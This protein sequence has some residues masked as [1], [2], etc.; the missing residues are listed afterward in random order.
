MLRNRDVRLIT[1]GRAL[2]FLGDQ[3]A[4]VAVLLH[5]HASGWG[6][7]GVAAVLVASA[8]PL[9][10]GA[11]LA[12]RL[13]DRVASRLL[14]VGTVVWEGCCVLALALLIA[15]VPDGPAT[16]G[17]TLVLLFAL[18]AG[19]AVSGPAWTALVPAVTERDEVGRAVG[20]VQAAMT[21]M[22]VAGPA[23]GGVLV[24]W[25][26]TVTA[27]AVDAGSFA[28]LGAAAVAVRGVRRPEPD[29]SGGS[30]I[31]AG[32]AWIRD[33][34]VL[35]P[36][37]TG[38]V[39][40]VLC[41]HVILVLEVFLV[42]DVLGGGPTAYGVMGAMIA[43]GMIAGSL[44]GGRIDGT[45]ARSRAVRTSFVVVAVGVLAAGLSPSLVAFGAA[46]AVVGLA[47]GVLT[48]CLNALLLARVPDAVR[49]RVLAAVVGV[50]QTCNLVGIVAGGPLG[51]LA[52]PRAVFVGAGCTGL[53][54]SAVVAVAAR[55]LTS[56][57]R[58]PGCGP[59]TSRPLPAPRRPWRRRS[60]SG[61]AHGGTR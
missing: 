34:A 60:G 52:G 6:T 37:V 28:A 18:G 44:V 15:V 41:L 27:L 45:P 55:G 47:N 12:G 20:T 16:I 50:V 38:M 40:L 19:Q 25:G 58:P 59:R 9:A 56:P 13:V 31:W 46:I 35:R 29:D 33:D 24:A 2:S 53:A 39:V 1:A 22:G 11:P 30:G 32:F 21:L 5:A 42:R 54:V 10:F 17:G 7:T 48:V 57:W 26:G 49:G 14:T 43:L 61:G 23:L 4:V 36:L 8:V 3:V 51:G